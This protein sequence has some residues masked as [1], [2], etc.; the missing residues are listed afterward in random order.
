ML[1]KP[2]HYYKTTSIS[3]RGS[4]TLSTSEGLPLID[5]K[6]LLYRCNYKVPREMGTK[7]DGEELNKY[8]IS[9]ESFN[10][11]SG[12][13][14]YCHTVYTG[15]DNFKRSYGNFFAHAIIL[16][17]KE[18]NHINSKF[19]FEAV[20]WITTLT[21][22]QDKDCKPKRPLVPININ[23]N[24]TIKDIEDVRKFC[25]SE[26][27]LNNLL[28]IIDIT[29][30][31]FRSPTKRKI[32]IQEEIENLKQLIYCIS[33]LLPPEILDDFSFTSYSENPLE[34]KHNIIGTVSECNF[35]YKRL[36]KDKYS[37]ININNAPESRHQFKHN[38]VSLLKDL[39][40]SND[41]DYLEILRDLISKINL[42]KDEPLRKINS[43][44]DLV[45]YYIKLSNYTNDNITIHYGQ[46][47]IDIT[48][49]YKSEKII[50]K[51][52]KRGLHNIIYFYCEI[53]LTLNLNVEYLKSLVQ[54][55][56]LYKDDNNQLPLFDKRIDLIRLLIKKGHNLNI[57]DLRSL[58]ELD[59][60]S[61]SQ[62]LAKFIE[63]GYS[64][65][66]IE[67]I[68]SKINS[69][70][71]LSAL[72]A[73]VKKYM[74]KSFLT[75]D[76]ADLY[77]RR[78]E[79]ILDYFDKIHHNKPY[80]D[81]DLLLG[82]YKNDRYHIMSHF[83]ESH[84]LLFIDYWIGKLEN[85][86]SRPKNF[87]SRFEEVITKG[88]EPYIN[89]NEKTITSILQQ[90][91]RNHDL[92]E[93]AEELIENKRIR[94]YLIIDRGISVLFAREIDELILSKRINKRNFEKT[95]MFLSFPEQSLSN[96][97]LNQLEQIYNNYLQR[98]REKEIKRKWTKEESLD[99]DANLNNLDVE[100]EIFEP[101]INK[102]DIHINDLI[103]RIGENPATLEKDISEIMNS[104][105]FIKKFCEV[106]INLIRKNDKTKS[107]YR[108][109]IET[110]LEK[111]DTEFF[112][113][114][115][116]CI[117]QAIYDDKIKIDAG[118]YIDLIMT[119]IGI[120]EV[121][122]PKNSPKE[123]IRRKIKRG[124]D[125]L[126]TELK[127]KL[128]YSHIK[129]L[130]KAIKELYDNAIENKM[131]ESQNYRMAN[132][133]NINDKIISNI[134]KYFRKRKGFIIY[135]YI[136]DVFKTVKSY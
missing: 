128:S 135:Y 105:Y 85:I 125:E 86:Y 110:C 32:V 63:S 57:N 100:D 19:I 79:V 48:N 62:I 94:R 71:Q 77:D 25:S 60:E 59:K 69:A 102:G 75:T 27:R 124:F 89:Y 40:I 58:I 56:L 54:N 81:I 95:K 108:W 44:L 11:N 43:Y 130:K 129:K 10:L 92:N 24:I 45:S 5:E 39:I 13:R 65:V 21:P 98:K 3:R 67:H 107:I 20:D 78:K 97:H 133:S 82:E 116:D 33:I 26:V 14:V 111:F 66:I 103:N 31:Q 72:N 109:Y 37:F 112:N 1:I 16:I 122:K 35:D 12:H 42:S 41:K 134:D 88:I 76:N 68:K 51:V 91:I 119:F 23:N 113:L 115:A 90:F 118:S 83:H 104:K 4:A 34:S 6:E 84:N 99:K 126:L 8:P 114:I 101:N 28:Y 120:I 87:T 132:H 9:I 70:T 121:E 49:E 30:T 74:S 36:P 80:K 18:T 127:R 46:E 53:L 55:Y 117:V 93:F 22:E 7:A 64:S 2:E 136:Y 96:N 73:F 131:R 38:Y 29:I 47:L 50:D 52:R 61:E 17:N 106:T 15:K 123:E